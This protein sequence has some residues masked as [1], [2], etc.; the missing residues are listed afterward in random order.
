[1]YSHEST[2]MLICDLLDSLEA[3]STHGAH[4]FTLFDPIPFL[5]YHMITCMHPL[6]VN[7]VGDL[8]HSFGHLFH[9]S[10]ADFIS[11]GLNFKSSYHLGADYKSQ[12]LS[13]H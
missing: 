13:H 10:G 6:C 5:F 12:E 8:I 2:D 7:E 11:I 4:A 9:L 1:M 3:I